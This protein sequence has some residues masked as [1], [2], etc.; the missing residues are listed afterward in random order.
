MSDTRRGRSAPT[1]RFHRRSG[2]PRSRTSRFTAL[3]AHDIHRQPGT[4]SRH[5]GQPQTT[6]G[7][8]HTD[9]CGRVLD[10][11]YRVDRAVGHRRHGRRIRSDHGQTGR[12]ADES[13][14]V[15]EPD[16]PDR[17]VTEARAAARLSDPH[18]VAV[19]DRG[20]SAD[21]V[22]LV[23]EHVPGRTLRQELTFGSSAAT[24]PIPGDP[25][26]RALQAS[27]RPTPLSCRTATSSPRTCRSHDQWRHRGHRLRA[28]TTI[29]AGDHRA[30]S[31]AGHSRL[32]GSGANLSTA[33]R[34][35]QRPPTAA[36]SWPSDVPPA[37]CRSGPIPDD[38]LVSAPDSAGA[39]I[40][41]DFV[42]VDR[43]F[44]ELCEKATAKDPADRFQTAAEML[45][46]VSR[47]RRISRPVRPAPALYSTVPAIA[48]AAP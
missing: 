3:L 37:M 31:A 13:R 25:H 42:E 40:P 15:Y 47:L 36:V 43:G 41:S 24:G 6:N 20:R 48:A 1:G 32:F 18:V 12:A 21:A 28:G 46:A 29:E 14:P 39:R 38:V 17:F 35:A 45:A 34:P 10:A 4:N 26:R 30:S 27:R 19:F 8:H 22:H 2:S 33:P 23:M 7:A 16:S 9:L 11:R 44:D 5:R